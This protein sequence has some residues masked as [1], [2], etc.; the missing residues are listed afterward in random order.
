MTIN[1]IK[2]FLP[3][4]DGTRAFG[5]ALRFFDAKNQEWVATWGKYYGNLLPK[6]RFFAGDAFGLLYGLDSNKKV[7]IFW[8]ET[9]D[10]EDLG[11]SE[12]EF[13]QLI[14]QDPDETINL[15]LYKDAVDKLGEPNLDQDFALKVETALGGQLSIDNLYICDRESHLIGLAKIATQIHKMP[16]GTRVIPKI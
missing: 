2:S 4:F 5:G 6:L 8:T 9:A 15:A 3:G 1:S 12:D 10:I 16:A 13:Y 11:V 14:Q 7:S